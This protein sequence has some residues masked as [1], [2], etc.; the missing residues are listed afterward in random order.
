MISSSN[1][2]EKQ[3]M[4]TGKEGHNADRHSGEEPTGTATVSRRKFL[5][6]SAAA[7][8]AGTVLG[9]SGRRLTDLARS[10][11]GGSN[12]GGR[13]LKGSL[14]MW[15]FSASRSVWEKKMAKRFMA[16]HP[17]VNVTVTVLPYFAM[18][19]KLAAAVLAGAGAPQLADVEVH[20]I[21]RFFKPPIGFV[22]LDSLIA[23]AGGKNQFYEAEAFGPATWQ[24]K[25]Y[26]VGSEVDPVIFYARADVLEK[27]G[28]S[29]PSDYLTAKPAIDTWDDFVAIGKEIK[30]ATGHYFA[31]ID[32]SGPGQWQM[33]METRGT[34]IFD[35][36]GR[37][38]LDSDVA[39]E[40]LSFLRDLIY[41]YKIAIPAPG[42]HQSTTE[43]YTAL[44]SSTVV[45]SLNAEWFGYYIKQAAPKQKGDWVIQRAPRWPSGPVRSAEYGG[46]WQMIPSQNP[47]EQQGLAWE[48]IRF[49]NFDVANIVPE[50]TIG[51]LFPSLRVASQGKY[52]AMYKVGDPY[53]RNESIGALTEQ[54][55]PT[56][57][58]EYS[59]PIMLDV[60]VTQGPAMAWEP[61]L[62]HNSA[63]PSKALR[64]LQSYAVKQLRS[65]LS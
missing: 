45:G 43:F 15:T 39:V 64:D 31:G 59:S 13:E 55:A 50:Y 27:V 4:G 12:S 47:R 60:A 53:F 38:Q 62:L 36:E 42:G 7:V 65:A 37:P 5:G 16:L 2:K 63:S 10:P 35:S 56:L 3:E 49:M 29:V 33:I 6:I 17:G 34:G 8:A 41:K 1:G 23:T 20:E 52:A 58:P 48:F 18:H 54:A 57:L 30:K 21:G 46:T 28:V 51:A 11:V 24:G 61:V 32:Y 19:D 22:A 25:T 26:G 14:E 9:R 40:T 44:S